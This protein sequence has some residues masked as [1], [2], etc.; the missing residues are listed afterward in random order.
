MSAYVN[1][2]GCLLVIQLATNLIVDRY[3]QEFSLGGEADSAYEYF[4]KEYLL[5]GGVKDQYKTLYLKSLEAAKKYL[6]FMP[7]V[8]GDPDIL[9]SGKYFVE[10]TSPTR[11][12]GNQRAYLR[13]D[14]QHL[15][16]N[17]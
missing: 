7:L 13:G 4:L 16:S 3:I 5:L 12:T 17:V 10:S 6:F 11:P 1:Q 14:M 8:E 15:V 2:W 9:F